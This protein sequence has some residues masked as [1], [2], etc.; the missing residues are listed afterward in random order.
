MFYNSS[1]F[2][3]LEAGV[4]LAWLQQQIATQNLSNIETPGYK[5][6]TLSFEAV[7]KDFEDE[8]RA[9]E[10]TEINGSINTSDA[11]SKRPD[12]NNV[13]SDA[14]SLAL[15]KAYAQY[16]MLLDKVKREFDGYNTV[17]GANM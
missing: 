4:Q 16:S 5:A 12:G 14:E 6:K 10:V 11:I 1:S 15:Y 9:P 2:K 17:L 7:M 8:K 3:T 13:D